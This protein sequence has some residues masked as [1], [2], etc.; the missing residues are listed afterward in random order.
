MS[1]SVSIENFPVKVKDLPPLNTL[2]NSDLLIVDR[3]GEYTG[4]V[5]FDVIVNHIFN[6]VSESFTY[7]ASN[8]IALSGSTFYLPP[9]SIT[10]DMLSPTVKDTI[11]NLQN[12]IYITNPGDAGS[13]LTGELTTFNEPITATG[14]FL[15]VNV[16]DRYRALRLWDFQQS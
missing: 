8:P 5:S 15:I 7:Y 14:D 6:I 11:A 12:P 4:R 10:Y 16:N 13:S 1:N 3:A 9:G 2:I